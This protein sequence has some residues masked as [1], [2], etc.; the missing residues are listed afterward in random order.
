MHYFSI[1]VHAHAWRDI[2]YCLHIHSVIRLSLAQFSQHALCRD[3]LERI[4]LALLA[5]WR[6]VRLVVTYFNVSSDVAGVVAFAP[7]NHRILNSAAVG[8]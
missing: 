8:T 3:A 4:R 1:L 2:V 5:I 7:V 6:A